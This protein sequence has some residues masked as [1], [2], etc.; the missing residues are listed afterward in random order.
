MFIKC[1]QHVYSHQF[2][3]GLLCRHLCSG[4]RSESM[5][6]R[7]D[8][9]STCCISDLLTQYVEAYI[10]LHK[11]ITITCYGRRP[12]LL[13]WLVNNRSSVLRP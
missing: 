12:A 8:S 3:S 9:H 11:Y 2:R 6:P 10:T 7:S 1:I 13:K 4:R 5:F